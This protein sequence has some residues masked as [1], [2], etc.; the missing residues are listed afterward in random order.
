M[1]IVFTFL[2]LHRI[3]QSTI[4]CSNA[5]TY[6]YLAVQLREM[7][8]KRSLNDRET[9]IVSINLLSFEYNKLNCSTL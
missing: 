7:K 5:Q 1:N 6:L 9:C 8:V 4:F 2:Y 3:L